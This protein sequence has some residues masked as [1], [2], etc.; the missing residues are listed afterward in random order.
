MSLLNDKVRAAF[1]AGH[2]V[3]LSTVNPDGSPQCS[4]VW[5]CIRGDEILLTSKRAWQKI[6]NV[7]RDPRVVLSMESGETSAVGLPEYLLVHGTARIEEGGASAVRHL[8]AQ[9]YVAEDRREEY[10]RRN[11]VPGGYVMH[12]TPLRLGGHGDWTGRRL[13]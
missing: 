11:D 5:A 12:I 1:Q 3:H 2:C 6:R 10:L 4:M 7:R 13:T 8:L 9:I